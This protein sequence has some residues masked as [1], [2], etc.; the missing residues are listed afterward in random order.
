MNKYGLLPLIKTMLS[1]YSETSENTISQNNLCSQ[2]T[3]GRELSLKDQL[4]APAG[5]QHAQITAVFGT[6]LDMDPILLQGAG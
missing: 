2:A 6:D 3:I 5:L 4:L 1:F